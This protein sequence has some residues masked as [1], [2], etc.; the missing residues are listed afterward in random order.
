MK[1]LVLLCDGMSDEPIKKLGNITPMQAAKKPAMDRLSRVSELGL[2]K[3]VQDNMKPG[4]DIANLSILGYDP[5]VY[6]SGRSPYEAASMGIELEPDDVAIRCNLVKLSNEDDFRDATML[7]YCADDIRTDEAAEIIA[8]VNDNLSGEHFKFHAGIQYRHCLVWKNGKLNLSMT[9]PHD[10]TGMRVGDYIKTN[11]NNSELLELMYKSYE[12]LKGKQANSI[13]LWGEGKR[14]ELPSFRDKFYKK[15]AMISAVD[16]LKGI[17]KFTGMDVINVP[18]ATG[19]LDTNFAGKCGAA[20]DALK[21]GT[22]LVYLHIEAPDEC[23]HRGEVEGK[24]KAIE[25]IDELVLKPFLAA[26]EN[27]HVRILICPD[28]ATPLSL[29]THT[30]DPVPYLIYDSKKLQKGAET[31]TEET[32]KASGNF[33]EVGHELMGRFLGL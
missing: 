2:V 10:I 31:F 1:Y 24:I 12:L 9:P 5:E 27:E 4:S 18:G 23:G 3:T 15:A 20:I 33:V 8:L 21:S 28:H 22:D 6:Y 32:A 14:R 30:N 26:F 29:R 7:S 25:L 13:W 17:G 16:L 11:E 19:Y